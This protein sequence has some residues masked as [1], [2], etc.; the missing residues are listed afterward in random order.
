MSELA[1]LVGYILIIRRDTETEYGTYAFC[2]F[3]CY[4]SYKTINILYIADACKQAL[5]RC[6]AGFVDRIAVHAGTVKI[7]YLLYEATLRRVLYCRCR[8]KE[9]VQR[10]VVILLQLVKAAP[11]CF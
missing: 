8:I 5:Q 1:D 7:T 4:F 6:K 3:L 2:M 10:L 9:L 11:P